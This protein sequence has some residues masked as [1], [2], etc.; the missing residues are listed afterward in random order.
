MHTPT[1]EQL[2]TGFLQLGY[3]EQSSSLRI[4]YEYEEHQECNMEGYSDADWG[5]DAI[6]GRSVTGYAF[7]A[8]GGIVTWRSKQQCV[9]ALSSVEADFVALS[10]AIGEA[11]GSINLFF[12]YQC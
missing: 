9:V 8:A 6:T 1:V 10:M 2:K 5:S 12:S 4:E 11:N 3:L 7:C